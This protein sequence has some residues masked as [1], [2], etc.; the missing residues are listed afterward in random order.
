MGRKVF[1]CRE[2]GQGCVLAIVGK[3]EEEVIEAQVRHGA[4]VHGAQDT[5]EVRAWIRERLRS[6]EEWARSLLNQAV[7]QSS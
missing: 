1:D 2:V 5:P 7:G 3:D 4:E 6:E